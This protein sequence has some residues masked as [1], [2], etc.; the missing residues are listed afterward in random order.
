MAA[1]KC[2]P[3]Y[4]AYLSNKTMHLPIRSYCKRY[5]NKKKKKKN[6]RIK[7]E[8]KKKTTNIKKFIIIE[9]KTEK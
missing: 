9:A 7:T 2:G 6:I 8:G 1:A 3:P 5:N 4:R